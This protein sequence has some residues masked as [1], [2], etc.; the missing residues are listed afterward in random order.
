MS[1]AA[2]VG[3]LSD[4]RLRV[5]TLSGYVFAARSNT[6]N[7]PLGATT[8]KGYL[9]TCISR[10]DWQV[11]IMLHRVV[12]IAANG[13]PAPGQQIDHINGIKDDN[14]LLNL[15]V[16]SGVENMRRAAKAGVFRNNGRD[17]PARDSKGRFG[18]KAAGRL[19]DG[20]EHNE[21]PERSR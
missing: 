8:A 14:R 13:I 1:D 2:I 21:F 20:V 7:K 9:R 19:L 18:K 10:G 16:V 15:D 12:W 4:G 17:D 6:P 11:S 5:D 3:L